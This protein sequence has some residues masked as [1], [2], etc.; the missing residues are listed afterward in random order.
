MTWGD[1]VVLLQPHG[2]TVEGMPVPVRSF[3]VLLVPG[4]HLVRRVTEPATARAL[5]LGYRSDAQ[6]GA[7]VIYAICRHSGIEPRFP[8]WPLIM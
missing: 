7:H 6:V 3:R 1:F 4:Y 2:I 8:G 5:P